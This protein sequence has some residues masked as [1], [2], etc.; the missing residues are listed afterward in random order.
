MVLTFNSLTFIVWLQQVMT[1]QH[2]VMLVRNLLKIETQSSEICLTKVHHN[3][4]HLNYATYQYMK[5]PA[6]NETASFVVK[7]SLYTLSF[8]FLI[9]ANY[10]NGLNKS[11]LTLKPSM[12]LS[13][14]FNKFNNFPSDFNNSPKILSISSTVIS[15]S[16]TS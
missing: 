14:L 2:L 15:I 12:N 7:A 3:C 10:Y 6:K 4:N 8:T 16:N 1:P 13:Y 5:F 9:V 11:W